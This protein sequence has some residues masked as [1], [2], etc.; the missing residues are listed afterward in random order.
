MTTRDLVAV[1]EIATG[2]GIDVTVEKAE[3][4]GIVT[5]NVLGRLHHERTARA[6]KVAEVKCWSGTDNL[7]QYYASISSAL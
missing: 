6:V 2:I 7:V 1:T 3:I 5:D 4:I